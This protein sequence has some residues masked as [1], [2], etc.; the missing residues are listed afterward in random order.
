V[1][2][3]FDVVILWKWRNSGA[4]ATESP[5]FFQLPDSHDRAGY[6]FE[7]AHMFPGF[8]HGKAVGPGR[9]AEERGHN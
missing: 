2:L 9:A 7:L 4:G 1:A 6:L 3:F 8:R 5:V